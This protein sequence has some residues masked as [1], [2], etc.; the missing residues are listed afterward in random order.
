MPSP[1]VSAQHL[2]P[3]SAAAPLSSSQQQQSGG[4]ISTGTD[5][6]GYQSQTFMGTLQAMIV[7]A[8]DVVDLP[9]ARFTSESHICSKIVHRVQALGRAWDEHPD[10][11]GRMWYVQLLLAVASLSRVV[12]WFE[13]ERQFWN[14]DDAS[15]STAGREGGGDEIG[16]EEGGE[17]LTFVLKPVSRDTASGL[18]SA[19]TPSTLSAIP[20]SGSASTAGG[21]AP[22]SVLNVSGALPPSSG[23]ALGMVTS[24]STSTGA[25]TPNTDGGIDGPSLSRVSSVH[26]TGRGMAATSGILPSAATPGIARFQ[27]P[28]VPGTL[29]TDLTSSAHGGE[30][31]NFGSSVIADEDALHERDL[32]F[33]EETMPPLPLPPPSL[34][35][36]EDAAKSQAE[37]FFP[38]D[39]E[40]EPEQSGDH[41]EDEVTNADRAEASEVLRVR[42]EEAQSLNVVLE[43]TLDGEG[44]QQFGWINPA[45]YDVIGYVVIL[46]VSML[47]EET[48]KSYFLQRTDPDTLLGTPIADH[49]A[50][51]D[52]D[53]FGEATRQLQEDDSHTLEV[54]FRIKVRPRGIDEAAQHEDAAIGRV[55]FREM[56]G[57]GMLMY[58]RADG[59]P[60]HTMWVIKPLGPPELLM[61]DGVELVVVDG[62]DNGPTS[63]GPGFHRR[64]VAEPVTPF[65]YLKDVPAGSVLCRICELEIPSWFFVKHN[66]TCNETHRIEASVAE[67]NESI[68]ELRHTVRE[69]REALDRPSPGAQAE[70]RGIPIFSPAPS[71]PNPISQFFKPP[72]GARLQKAS[73]R[74]LQH[75]L[76]GQIE[77]I[78]QVAVEI[79]I[80]ALRSDQASEPIER[81]RLLSPESLDRIAQA[82]NW[83]KPTSDDPALAQL[84]EDASMLVRSK[85]EE[86]NRLSNTL[87][88]AEKVRQE[89]EDDFLARQQAMEAAV[90]ASKDRSTSLSSVGAGSEMGDVSSAASEYAFD[91]DNESYSHPTP[92]R[93]A[94][95]VPGRPRGTWRT[96]LIPF[97]H[98]SSSHLSISRASTPP[99]IS[100]PLAVAAPIVASFDE[101]SANSASLATNAPTVQSAP[102]LSSTQHQPIPIQSSSQN[103]MRGTRSATVSTP[104]GLEPKFLVTPPVSPLI[105]PQEPV[106]RG[107]RRRL[108]NIPALSP[109]SCSP[110]SGTPQGPLS[111]RIITGGHSRAPPSSIKDFD[112]IKPISKGAFGSVF[113]AKKKVTGDYYAIKVLR[114]A[115]MIS[116]NQITNVKA[117]RMILMKQA[118]S[119]FVVKLYY[120]FQSKDNLY[121][122]MEYL[123]GG[124]CAA[125]IKTLG[126]L[127]EE[128]AKAYVAE[129]VLGLEYLHTR[130]VIHR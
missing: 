34:R 98:P 32:E 30:F 75:K 82:R 119:P 57:K 128:W 64:G 42:A 24:S 71:P 25:S 94:S 95:P 90:E 80:P 69:L 114:K 58:D 124:D 63:G 126:S 121:L 78:L 47:T 12:E 118:E 74:K 33:E 46:R 11:H 130:G 115:D 27:P 62:E 38:A 106:I 13:A 31:E 61:S 113:L 67:C 8:T 101:T 4:Q 17:M 116:K 56:E 55:W 68:S 15:A 125:L 65:P 60:S 66:D 10:W 108:S 14:F 28:P 50:P 109:V 9:I 6:D 92:M 22:G 37:I 1:S 48:Q 44:G 43:L 103:T 77:D 110:I 122:V 52:A 88:Y 23:G 54:Q 105:S 35:D 51:A 93:A 87:R 111:P 5:R 70:Y 83:V 20:S 85:L 7:I 123:N 29:L 129:V 19:V 107:H 26:S 79:S 36:T 99:S 97:N 59:T 39:Q 127:P 100:S 117:E 120:T 40:R 81:Q 18:N 72:L 73:V 112:I 89:W 91:A 86:V 102:P 45:W 3:A 96:P 41:P 2:H 76:L 49:L 21:S 84:V 16:D 53:V 104:A